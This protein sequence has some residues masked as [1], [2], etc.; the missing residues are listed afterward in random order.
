[1]VCAV[2]GMSSVGS[3]ARTA[4]WSTMWLSC[5]FESGEL[6]VGQSEARQMSDMRDIVARQGGHGLQDTGQ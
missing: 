5:P 4:Y 3:S 2:G 6:V 1:M